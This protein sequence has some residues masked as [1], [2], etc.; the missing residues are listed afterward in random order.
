MKQFL[1]G[2]LGSAVLL[3]S[4]QTF[5]ASSNSKLPAPNGI[6]AYPAIQNGP[7]DLYKEARRRAEKEALEKNYQELKDAAAELANA[8][9]ELSDEI[10][11]TGEHVISARVFNR[12]ERIEKL[13]KDVRDKAK[14]AN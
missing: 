10:S 14:G 5:A 9:K 11:Q 6:T 7:T 8:S 1:Y 4:L 2:M 3:A 12:L 13:V